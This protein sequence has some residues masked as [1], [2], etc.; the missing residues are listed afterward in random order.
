MKHPEREEWIPFLF[1]E[2]SS[3][4]RKR[5]NQHLA[6]CPE[7]AQEIGGWRRSLRQLDRWPLPKIPNPSASTAEPYLKWALAAILVLS[8]GILV[9]RLSAPKPISVAD[10]R[11]QVE[12]SV[13]ASIQSEL[14]V[15][16]DE[17]QTQ[18]ANALQAAEVRVLNA[19]AG[20]KQ[21][22]WR[23][24]LQMLNTTRAADNRALLARLEQ[25]E[26]RQDAQIVGVRKDLETL[27]S[28]ADEEIRDA[29]L[30]LFQL[31]SSATPLSN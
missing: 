15:A 3:S 28:T 23:E 19:S 10:L 20:D 24:M 13:R 8:L 22:L 14:Q 30:K 2:T 4:D 21:Q 5:L 11:S 1:G 17:F 26:D 29:R 7:C 6:E 12:A 27:A 18:T 16:L 25:L 9:G 31:A